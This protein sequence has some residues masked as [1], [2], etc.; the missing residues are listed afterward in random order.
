MYK[1]SETKQYIINTRDSLIKYFNIIKETIQGNKNK[2][3]SYLYD[4]CNN[5]YNSHKKIFWQY[6]R[7]QKNSCN[8]NKT[9]VKSQLEY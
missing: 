4:T 3:N 8:S 6:S 2:V 5:V 9:A 1:R 7:A